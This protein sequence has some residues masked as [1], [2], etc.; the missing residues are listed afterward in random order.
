M[1]IKAV[2]KALVDVPDVNVTFNEDHIRKYHKQ[3]ICFAVAMDGGLITPIIP[4]V[5]SKGMTEIAKTTKEL[6]GK[7]KEKKL[8][9]EEY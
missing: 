5:G 9:P 1:I 4:D 2:Q 8:K 7:A 3:D 6:A